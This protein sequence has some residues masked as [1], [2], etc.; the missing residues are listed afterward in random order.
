MHARENGIYHVHTVLLLYKIWYRLPFAKLSF[1]K[2]T[3]RMNSPNIPPTKRSCYTVIFHHSLSIFK[4]GVRVCLFVCPPPRLLI[5][6]G[7]MWCDIDPIQL[8]K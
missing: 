5:T 8:V 1:A 4:P 2:I 6:S 7:L 3:G